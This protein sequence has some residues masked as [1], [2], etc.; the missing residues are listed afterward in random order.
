MYAL[1]DIWKKRLLTLFAVVALSF[2]FGYWVGGSDSDTVPADAP[3]AGLL[4]KVQ[5][6]EGV[7]Y[8]CPMSCV[9]P[10]EKPGR[11]PVCGMDLVPVK[12]ADRDRPR[13][14]LS[15]EAAQLARLQLATAKRKFVTAEIMMFGQIDYDPAHMAEIAAFMPGVIDRLYIKRAGQF[16]R[17]GDPLFDIYSP[18]LL[19][20]QQQLLEALKYVPSFLA[21][22]EGRPHVARDVPVMERGERETEKR[23]PEEKEALNTIAAL[24]HKLSILGMPKRDIDQFMK[25]GEATGIATVYASMYGQV[26]EQNS[27]EGTYVNVGTPVITIA[28]PQY[29]WARLD[30]YEADFPWIRKGQKVSFVTDAYPGETFTGKLVYIDP[31]FNADTRTFTVGAVS[32]DIGS[33]LKA[34]MLIRAKIH[35]NL[36]ADGKLAGED[37]ELDRAPLAIPATAPLITGK[38]AVVY[39]ADPEE[40]GMYEG[41]EV[42]LGP[43]GENHYIVLE[44]LQ[45]G[46]RVVVNGNFKIDSAVQILAK[47]S[48]MSREGRHPATTQSH[49]GGSQVVHEDYAEE[50]M[51]SRVGPRSETVEE[52]RSSRTAPG[53]DGSDEHLGSVRS[54]HRSTIIRRKPGSYGDTTRQMRPFL[55]ESDSRR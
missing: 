43:K 38:R 14:R 31:V 9:P 2:L 53:P 39:V 47:S 54:H 48:M 10:M 24:R 11:C 27:Y 8:L 26:I 51:K 37:A 18:D 29:V 35:A 25:V 45:E 30:V 50:R 4:D 33:R 15:Q 6:V 7:S 13:V 49:Q 52:S 3:S 12:D 23:S 22:Q 1:N 19:A 44:G 20:T 40:E 55:D 42:L 32:P 5:A 28:D 17:W 41:R 16:V 34:G 46:E 36:T 21:F